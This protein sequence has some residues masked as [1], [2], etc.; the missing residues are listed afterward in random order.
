MQKF[1]NVYIL[2][3]PMA[4]MQTHTEYFR[5]DFDIDVKI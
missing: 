1:E 2:K 3:S 4:I 5:S